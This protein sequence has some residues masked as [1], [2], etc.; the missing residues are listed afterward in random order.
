LAPRSLRHRVLILFAILAVGPLLILGALDYARARRAVERLI[1]AQTDTSAARAARLIADQYAL[2]ESDAI[3]LGDN[4]ETQRLFSS[5]SAGDSSRATAAQ[6][7]AEA[8]AR[9][10]WSHARD[11]YRSLELRDPRG[12]AVIAINGDSSSD[13]IAAGEALPPVEYPIV[14]SGGTRRFGV[15]VLRPRASS[16][17]PPALNGLS[18]G[19]SGFL[20]VSDSA[21]GRLLFD[22][23]RFSAPT[24]GSE[25]I[26]SETVSRVFGALRANPD[27]ASIVYADADSERVLSAARIAGAGWV[28]L[29]STGVREFTAGLSDLRLADL[30]V[31]LGIAAVVALLF[32]LLIAR[33]T[34]S[35]EA[36]TRAAAAVGRGD[37]SPPIPPASEDEVGT[38]SGAFDHMLQRLRTMLHEIEISRQ[39][40]VLG[41]FSA[42][43]SHE[44][45]NPLTS[46]KL[47]LQGLD[48]NVRRG[49]IPDHAQ[50]AIDT[51]LREVTRLDRVVRGVLELARP[52]KASRAARSAHAILRNVL[53]T[54]QAEI[55][56]R[57]IVLVRRLEASSDIVNADQERLVSL[58]TNLV[59]NAIEAQPGGGRVLVHTQTN[60]ATIHVVVADDGPGIRA[61]L[62]D[63][64]FRPFVSGKA[65]GTG[66]GLSMALEAARDHG[67]SI[68]LT[69]APEDFSGAAFDVA[70]PLA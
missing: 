4:A 30:S 19:H 59:V 11:A 60:G 29:S 6:R 22:S 45:R 21:G 70:L 67:G 32:T 12:A 18:F 28:V 1:A 42:Q 38:L 46:L 55:D 15:V 54:H 50:P 9:T 25:A 35:L 2:I 23:R 7:P 16:L 26:G 24:S 37:L 47:N 33:S 51:C 44:V 65:T 56:A 5:L 27:H 52:R 43:L 20:L 41:E 53:E 57:G 69:T 34:R 68:N 8:F 61:D 63:R 40:A 39:L 31:V 10:V 3:L 64:M 62:I 14:E 66:L 49:R 17:L 36:L 48:R 13:G 58:F